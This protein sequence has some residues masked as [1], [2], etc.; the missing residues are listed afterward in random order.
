MFMLDH[1][2][3]RTNL[4]DPGY[5]CPVCGNEPRA[6][7]TYYP[8]L[9]EHSQFTENDGLQW[10]LDK[11]RKS[12]SFERFLERW[13]EEG[14]P[15]Y[16]YTRRLT[17]Q[18]LRLDLNYL[19]NVLHAFIASRAERFE[20]R[21]SQLGCEAF[22]REW[23][24]PTT[25]QTEAQPGMQVGVQTMDQP[26][27][28][29]DSQPGM[30]TPRPIRQRRS[31]LNAYT[32]F[33][34]EFIPGASSW[35]STHRSRREAARAR[36]EFFHQHQGVSENPTDTSE[37]SLAVRRPQRFNL[38]PR[39]SRRRRAHRASGQHPYPYQYHF[40]QGNT[41]WNFQGF[42]HPISF[43]AHVQDLAHIESEELARRLQE[44]GLAENPLGAQ[45]QS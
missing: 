21:P 26:E 5:D 16:E 9:P 44:V 36:A 1:A 8:P 7:P 24:A 27:P 17:M 33:R 43:P 4:G 22:L 41:P 32:A 40:L 29:L 3:V 10:L 12:S 34:G 15:R 20:F 31:G 18:E 11:Y 6:E 25:A 45:T 35:S 38:R 23:R 14:V 37:R 28:P 39:P 2:H 19:S 42:E 13:Q 30:Q